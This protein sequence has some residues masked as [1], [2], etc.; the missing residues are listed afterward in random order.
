VYQIAAQTDPKTAT[1]IKSNSGKILDMFGVAPMTTILSSISRVINHDPDNE[2]E[3]F[4][5]F[6]KRQKWLAKTG[7]GSAQ[8]INKAV[9]ER[10]INRWRVTAKTSVTLAQ[11]AN[12]MKEAAGKA[13]K[14]V[15]QLGVF[16][17]RKNGEPR[18]QFK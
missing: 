7:I 8:A 4:P 15:P 1:W 10:K 14:G 9:N 17:L 5:E 13:L 12:D 18:K 16:E 3:H 6:V 11:R 2:V